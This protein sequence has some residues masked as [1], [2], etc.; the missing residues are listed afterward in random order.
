MFLKKSGIINLLLLLLFHFFFFSYKWPMVFSD[1]E[2]SMTWW[3]RVIDSQQ[4]F[5][6]AWALDM[7]CTDAYRVVCMCL[8]NNLFRF[9]KFVL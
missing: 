9:V 5:N 7:I 1:A 4:P 6:A 2:V 3:S 8:E